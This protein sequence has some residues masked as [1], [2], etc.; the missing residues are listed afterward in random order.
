MQTVLAHPTDRERLVIGAVNGGIWTTH[1]A[2][3]G[4]PP[5]WTPRT[6]TQRSQSI[7]AMDFDPMNPESLLAGYGAA[8]SY[9]FVAGELSGLIRSPD[10]GDT[11]SRVDV[12]SA[13][14]PVG[15]DIH[16]VAIRGNLMLVADRRPPSG[17]A[18]VLRS[19]DGGQNFS[20]AGVPAG[21]VMDLA[22]DP[23][24]PQRF[25]VSIAGAGIYTTGDGG[26]MWTPASGPTTCPGTPP[27]LENSLYDILMNTGLGEA[28]TELAVGGEGRVYAITVLQ[29]QPWYIGYSDNQGDDWTRMDIPRIPVGPNLTIQDV[30]NDPI[31]PIQITTAAPHGLEGREEDRIHIEGV[32]GN[33]AANG[34][35]RFTVVDDDTIV[36]AQ[37]LTYPGCPIVGNVPFEASTAILLPYTDTSPGEEGEEMEDEEDEGAPG[38]SGSEHLSIG[39]DP[40]DQT[41]VYIGGDYQRRPTW[42]STLGAWTNILGALAPSGNLWRGEASV[43][44]SGQPPGQ[45]PG[46]NGRVPS[47]QWKNLTHNALT[48][49][50]ELVGGGTFSGSAPH[51]DSRDMT[52]DYYGNLIE[53]DDGGIF[54]RTGPTTSLGDWYSLNGNLS[55]TEIAYLAYDPISDRLIAGAQDVGSPQSQ[56]PVG[57][58]GAVVWYD[59]RPGSDGGPVQVDATNPNRSERYTS[60]QEWG[61][62]TRCGYNPQGQ[63]VDVGGNVVD[64]GLNCR[65]LPLGMRC[66]NV[67]TC[68]DTGLSCDA[69]KCSAVPR[70]PGCECAASAT[71]EQCDGSVF[72]VDDLPTGYPFGPTLA[73]NQGSNR[74]VITAL[75]SLYESIDGGEKLFQVHDKDGGPAGATSY[76]APIVNGHADDSELIYMGICSTF[77][78]RTVRQALARSGAVR[79]P[80]APHQRSGRF[81]DGQQG[82]LRRRLRPGRVPRRDRPQ[83]SLHDDRRGPDCLDGSDG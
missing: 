41:I 23:S 9:G 79:S 3:A 76:D 16:G 55:I 1:N 25:Y 65:E 12:A 15:R 51:A 10:F 37:C 70:D 60:Y 42:D 77:L 7:G 56:A 14:T 8:S 21:S 72:P 40:T 32:Q 64:E 69:G 63:P 46:P 61:S 81:T 73:L 62:P 6:N 28:Y 24:D 5:T 57:T 74:F 34:D 54:R 2:Y 43:A 80:W 53:V 33:E 67:P 58:P 35:F 38:G 82:R 52:F 44:P 83:P 75:N 68:S 59:V 27:C 22:G 36:L 47:P 11:W 17:E 78:V 39:V 4:N 66:A 29:G 48:S 20:L 45:D 19:D 13:V 71:C 18:G 26:Q 30:S 31:D 50:P 49:P